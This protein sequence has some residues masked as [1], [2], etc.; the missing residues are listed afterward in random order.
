MY[1]NP[2]RQEGKSQEAEWTLV[3]SWPLI[4]YHIISDKG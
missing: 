4:S 3:L 2:L 1:F